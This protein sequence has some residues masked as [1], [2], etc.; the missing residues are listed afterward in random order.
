MK[1][2][3]AARTMSALPNS[4]ADMATPA[5]W[6]RWLRLELGARFGGWGFSR[7]ER[8]ALLFLIVVILAGALFRWDQNRRLAR[9][10]HIWA[11]APGQSP[12]RPLIRNATDEA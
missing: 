10:L 2:S 8:R 3:T 5:D 9:E 11:A 4:P 6:W 1:S 12:P 7:S